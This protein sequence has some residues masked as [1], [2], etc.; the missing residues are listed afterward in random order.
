MYVCY[1]NL[2][3]CPNLT[4]LVSFYRCWQKAPEKRPS[5]DEVVSI[6]TDLSEFFSH[7]LEPVEYSLS[8][9]NV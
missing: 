5:M 9:C 1:C 2:F 3:T 8:T 6:M 7:H 4:L